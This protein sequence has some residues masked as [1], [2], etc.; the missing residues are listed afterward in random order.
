MPDPHGSSPHGTPPQ[1]VELAVLIA[2]ALG[3]ALGTLARFAIGRVLVPLA[4]GIPLATLVVNTTGSFLLGFL[5]ARTAGRSPSER[6]LR[7]FAAIGFCGGFTTFSTLVLEIDQGLGRLAFGSALAY[8]SITVATGLLA[9][10]GG[11][12]VGHRRGGTATTGPDIVDP[13]AL[14]DASGGR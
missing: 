6:L 3:G 13:D 7:P 2:I 1:R 9:A 10:A 5:V 4:N 12:G 8:L 11:A 14:D